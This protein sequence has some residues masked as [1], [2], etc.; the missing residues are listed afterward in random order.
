VVGY[1]QGYAVYV[2]EDLE[3]YHPTGQAKFLETPARSMARELIRFV[4][5]S[6]RRQ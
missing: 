6:M 1:S 2:H 5:A 3:A 4:A